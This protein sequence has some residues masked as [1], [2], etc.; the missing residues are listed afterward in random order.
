M[1]NL[2]IIDGASGVWKTDLVEYVSNYLIDSTLIKKLT[3]RRLRKNE[4]STKLDLKFITE[5]EFETISPDYQ[6]LY[7]GKK[8]GV[9]DRD[10]KEAL[11]K[12]VNVFLIVRNIEIIN[13]LKRKYINCK[14]TTVFIYTDTNEV[15]K[16]IVPIY[17]KGIIESAKEAFLDYLRCPETYDEVLVNGAAANDF[18]RL[19]NMLVQ[20]GDSKNKDHPVKVNNQNLLS[21][22]GFKVVM[23]PKLRSVLALI[24]GG[25]ASIALA[26]VVNMVTQGEW[27]YWK[28]V[29]TISASLL[30]VFLAMLSV[31]VVLASDRNEDNYDLELAQQ[32]N[33]PDQ[34]GRRFS[35]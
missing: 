7:N 32:F 33:T 6:Y 30:I 8:Y 23:Q 5:N 1:G 18:Y 3:T 10:I 35:K 13:K 2:F 14:L 17:S 22:I 9:M 26:F 16:R 25:L 4:T 15:K 34:K 12:F 11:S 28:Y 31:I 27:T 20:R 24:L 19:I 21:K 29:S